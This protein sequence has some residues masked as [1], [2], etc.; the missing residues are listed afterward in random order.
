MVRRRKAPGTKADDPKQHHIVPA[1]YLA[2]FTKSLSQDGSLWVFRYENAAHF[3]TSPK[4]ACRERDFFR[5]I[6]SSDAGSDPYI[7]ERV[8]AWHEGEVAPFVHEIARDGRVS[9]RRQVAESISLGAALMGRSRRTREV[10]ETMLAMNVIKALRAETVTRAEWER[11]REDEAANGADP[12]DC[13]AYEDARDRALRGNW[14]PRA[15]RA[16]LVAMIPEL[17]DRL[18]K[19]LRTR[20]WELMVTDAE[21]TGGFVTSDAPV[22]WG[23]LDRASTGLDRGDL[24]DP[25]VE[26]TFPISKDAALV[27]HTGAGEANC[28]ATPE[29]V[30]HVNSRTVHMT[31]GIVIHAGDD[32]LLRRRSGEIRHGS[33][34][35]TYVRD[36][37]RRGIRP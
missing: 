21:E 15:P 16:V 24:S 25:S 20:P 35:F 8:L 34:Y 32:F 26:V 18:M 33:E 22:T 19:I 29:I 13:P 3:R 17:Q 2:G 23:D 6:D 36:C 1:F 5:F 7:F 4:K 31:D 9:D 27:S 10:M 37:N 14:R 12:S 28:V 11:Y 30:A